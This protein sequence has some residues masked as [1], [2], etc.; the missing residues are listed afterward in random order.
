MTLILTTELKVLLSAKIH[1]MPQE[2]D[3]LREVLRKEENLLAVTI[4][5]DHGA[6]SFLIQE[7]QLELELEAL[8]AKVIKVEADLN[9]IQ[10][11]QETEI[12]LLAA[13]TLFLNHAKLIQQNQVLVGLKK[14]LILAAIQQDH[15]LAIVTPD[16]DSLRLT[17]ESQM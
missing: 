2:E 5:E 15:L 8:Q 7:N 3:S 1:L 17:R 4:L 6:V 11:R 9:Q 13:A 16:H 10:T 14:N 12:S